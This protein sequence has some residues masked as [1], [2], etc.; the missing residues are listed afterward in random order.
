MTSGSLT[1]WFRAWHSFPERELLPFRPLFQH[2]RLDGKPPVQGLLEWDSRS[3]SRSS[4]HS[5]D[6]RYCGR[7][8]VVT[9]RGWDTNAI[10]GHVAPHMAHIG[11]CVSPPFSHHCAAGLVGRSCAAPRRRPLRRQRCFRGSLPPPTG[12]PRGSRR[13]GGWPPSCRLPSWSPGRARGERVPDPY[14]HSPFPLP[15]HEKTCRNPASDSTNQTHHADCGTHAPHGDSG[16]LSSLDT[17]HAARALRRSTP[18]PGASI[19]RY[20]SVFCC[21]RAP[22]LWLSI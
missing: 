14:A 7:S 1:R 17:P 11:I 18:P 12:G 8:A 9:N 13:R 3:G 19:G 22:W 10:L 6:D 20:T 21:G 2:R 4:V 15:E 16:A 5:S